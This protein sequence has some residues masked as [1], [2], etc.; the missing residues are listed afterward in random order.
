MTKPESSWKAYRQMY[1]DTT[2]MIPYGTRIPVRTSDL[3]W[4]TRYITHAKQNPS[5]SSTTT[6][7]SVITEVVTKSFHQIGSVSTVT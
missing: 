2:V 7:A 6:L 1:A 5:T 4:M 3:P